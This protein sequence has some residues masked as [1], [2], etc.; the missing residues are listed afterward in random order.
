MGQKRT[1]E[2]DGRHFPMEL[3]RRVF[4]RIKRHTPLPSGQPGKEEIVKRMRRFE[5]FAKLPSRVIAVL[6]AADWP[7]LAA[8]PGGAGSGGSGFGGGGFSGGGFG[9]G[10]GGSW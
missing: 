3:P 2:A 10:G 8:V 1:P 5:F 4:R 7:A 6:S 9:G